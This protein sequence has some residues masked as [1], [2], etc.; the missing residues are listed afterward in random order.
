MTCLLGPSLFKLFHRP[1]E[2]QKDKGPH[3]E[4]RKMPAGWMR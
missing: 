1:E 3:I 2:E 4:K